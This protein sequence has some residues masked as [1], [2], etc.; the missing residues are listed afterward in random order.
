MA[1][2]LPS[3]WKANLRTLFAR[4]R[5]RNEDLS[6]I[7]SQPAYRPVEAPSLQILNPLEFWLVDASLVVNPPQ[8]LCYRIAIDIFFN[9]HHFV[10]INGKAGPEH[11]HSYRLQVK[12]SSLMQALN[13][14][15]REKMKQVVSAYNNQLLNELPP[16]KGLQ[17]TTEN[18]TGVLFQ[19]LDRSF[20]GLPVR[21]LE[22]TVWE[23]PTEGVTVART[24]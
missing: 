10:V 11:S 18:L 24:A 22:I 7:A 13:N 12:C 6:F 5:S 20:L 16:F 19:Q 14:Q 2:T 15:L 17:P 23:S 21:L 9:A 3:P 4:L 8:G 1:S